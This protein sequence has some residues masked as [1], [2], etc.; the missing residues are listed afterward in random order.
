MEEYYSEN[1]MRDL[2]IEK[3]Y[4]LLEQISESDEMKDE[5]LKVL[6]VLSYDQESGIRTQVAEILQ[7]Y[8]PRGVEN[9][10]IR[11]SH[12]EDGLVRAIACDSLR[13]SD[14][15]EVLKLLMDKIK[16]DKVDL[17]RGYASS[18]IANIVLNMELNESQYVDFFIEILSKEK[19]TWVKM[20]IYGALYLLGAE[21]YLSKL[22][23]MVH[24]KHFR[25][26]AAAIN[27]LADVI[28]DE[29]KELIESTLRE[30]LDKEETLVVRSTIERVL[31]DI[32]D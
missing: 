25:K 13:L 21:S 4:E 3:K 2:A 27:I 14:T 18:S 24:H 20:H 11:L 8:D 19:V 30:L 16:I 28:S 6:D 15:Q 26:R 22:I 9:I 12:D 17:V 31:E 1:D 10:L 5:Y 23:E 32:E 7:D 29:N